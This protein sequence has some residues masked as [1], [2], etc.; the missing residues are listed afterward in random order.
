MSLENLIPKKDTMV[1]T[2]LSQKNDNLKNQATVVM[3]NWQEVENNFS[4]A[5]LR[6]LVLRD[7]EYPIQTASASAEDV[8][9]YFFNGKYYLGLFVPKTKQ[10]IALATP[11]FTYNGRK[12]ETVNHKPGIFNVE[13]IGKSQSGQGLFLWFHEI[14][15]KISELLL[16]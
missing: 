8:K 4:Q 15:E 16:T 6:M 10:V 12:I 7:C 2:I 14:Y 5:E 3:M 1:E 13:E 11:D 9:L